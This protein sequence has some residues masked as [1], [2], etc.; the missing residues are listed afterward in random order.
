VEKEILD[1]DSNNGVLPRFVR[2]RSSFILIENR[3]DRRSFS[4]AQIRTVSGGTRPGLLWLRRRIVASP[5]R[6]SGRGRPPPPVTPLHLAALISNRDSVGSSAKMTSGRAATHGHS[7][8]LL[9]SHPIVRTDDGEGATERS[10]RATTA[11]SQPCPPSSGR[12]NAVDVLTC[13]QGRYE[14]VGWKTNPILSRRIRF[15]AAR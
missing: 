15:S 7:R 2:C 11:S 12:R 6:P 1:C 8:P 4:L 10:N 5:S 9:L 3:R 13:C 14:V